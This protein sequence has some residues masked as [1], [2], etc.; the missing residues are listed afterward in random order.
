MGSSGG[1]GPAARAHMSGCK[2]PTGSRGPRPHN[3]A[4]LE[5]GL[6]AL[7]LHSQVAHRTPGE[8][9]GSGLLC[10]GQHGTAASTTHSHPH[11]LEAYAG[12]IGAGVFWAGK[13]C[14]V[15]ASWGWQPPWERRG[16]KTQ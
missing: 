6:P 8:G 5:R 7:T 12:A 13:P 2:V 14:P 3:P 11:Q 1:S 4:L 15:G 9:V 16:E 10:W